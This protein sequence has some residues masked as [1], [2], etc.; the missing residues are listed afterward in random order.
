MYAGQYTRDNLK[1][2]PSDG[3]T[4]SF[5]LNM[6]ITIVPVP[7]CVG[8]AF[9]VATSRQ[10]DGVY[11]GEVDVI[12]NET[13]N[14]TFMVGE[15]HYKFEGM[16]LMTKNMLSGYGPQQQCVVMIDLLPDE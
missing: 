12:R 5:M 4:Y 1:S 2:L 7:I 6:K 14:F 10:W 3:E 13:F 16:M 15:S 9:E 8:T 11:R